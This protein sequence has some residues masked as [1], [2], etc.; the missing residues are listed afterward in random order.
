[1]CTVKLSTVKATMAMRTKAM[2]ASMMVGL[3][4]LRVVCVLV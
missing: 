2:I 3:H 4:S 1:M